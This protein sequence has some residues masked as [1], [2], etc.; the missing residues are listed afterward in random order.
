MF[1]VSNFL[2]LYLQAATLGLLIT[3]ANT[4]DPDRHRQNIFPVRS[5][6]KLF[7]ALI[8]FLKEFLK[9]LQLKKVSR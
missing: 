3:F 5:G 7:D 4:L 8:V 9:K 1:S 2:P 6:S